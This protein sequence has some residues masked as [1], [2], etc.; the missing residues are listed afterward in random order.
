MFYHTCCFRES[1]NFK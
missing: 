1:Y